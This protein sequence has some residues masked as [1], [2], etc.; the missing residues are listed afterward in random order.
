[1]DPEAVH[2]V[3][4]R[5]ERREGIQWAADESGK[6]A[7]TGEP[8]DPACEGRRRKAHGDQKEKEEKGTQDLGLVF[9]RPA[10]KR[11]KRQENFHSRIRVEE[12]EF[13]PREPEVSME[14]DPFGRIERSFGIGEKA[15]VIMHGLLMF[16]HSAVPPC[17]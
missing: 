11:I 6:D 13:L 15:A 7:V 5:A 2:K 9:R 10:D 4:I 8:G 3:K 1:M 16:D 17:K 14:P 12:L